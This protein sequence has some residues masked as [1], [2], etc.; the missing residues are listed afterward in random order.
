MHDSLYVDEIALKPSRSSITMSNHGANFGG[1]Q[2]NQKTI[3]M[4]QKTI[5]DLPSNTRLANNER[6]VGKVISQKSVKPE[7]IHNVLKLA[8]VRYEKFKISEL[9]DMIMLFEFNN[10]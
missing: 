6:Y 5:L 10:Q 7:A 1:Q 8:W 2:M 9:E 3:P 4:N